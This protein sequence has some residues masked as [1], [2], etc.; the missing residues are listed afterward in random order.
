MT[1]S[2]TASDLTFVLD[3]LTAREPIFHRPAFG[4]SRADFEKLM[5][6]D[7]WEVGASGRRYDRVFILAELERNPPL[8]AEVS[9]WRVCDNAVRS[10]GENTYLLTYTLHQGNR[11]TRRATIWQKLE[12]GWQILYHQG[13][14]VT[15]KD[16]DLPTPPE[17]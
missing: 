9:G 1:F 13:T 3:E 16:D 11:I 12:N 2:H 7:Y 15:E 4:Q 17:P 6:P 5:A 8:D 14:I 10:M